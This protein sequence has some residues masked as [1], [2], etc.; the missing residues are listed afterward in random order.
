MGQPCVGNGLSKMQCV[1]DVSGLVYQ[2]NVHYTFE[3][4]IFF[5]SELSIVISA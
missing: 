5:S 2:G 4:S 1:Y 3:S